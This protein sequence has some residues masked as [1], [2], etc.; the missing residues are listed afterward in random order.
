VQIRDTVERDTVASPP[1]ASTRVASTSRVDSPRTN[2]A[3]T[4]LSSAW[5]LVTPVPSS[6]EANAAVVPRSLGR[7]RVTG[8]VVVLIVMSQ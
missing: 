5:V 3:I 1:S 8:P 2:P 7:D 6:R 4:R